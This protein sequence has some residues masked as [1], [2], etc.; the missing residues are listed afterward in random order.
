MT[1]H[2]LAGTDVFDLLRHVRSGSVRV[3]AG[4]TARPEDC[5]RFL[6][7]V[8]AGCRYAALWDGDEPIEHVK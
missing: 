8:A 3:L 2:D 7:A 6:D 5:V 4:D 1:G